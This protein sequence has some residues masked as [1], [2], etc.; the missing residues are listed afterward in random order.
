MIITM[1]G[2]VGARHQESRITRP[3]GPREAWAEAPK[4]ILLISAFVIALSPEENDTYSL[5]PN[6]EKI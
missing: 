4:V 3:P 6:K 2:K 5:G 1:G